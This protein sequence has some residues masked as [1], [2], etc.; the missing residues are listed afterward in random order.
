MIIYQRRHSCFS[1]HS[2]FLAASTRNLA[3]GCVKDRKC[4][5]SGSHN[6]HRSTR[7]WQGHYEWETKFSPIWPQ[8]NSSVLLLH[9]SQMRHLHV[10]PPEV[11]QTLQTLALISFISARVCRLQQI[12]KKHMLYQNTR[13]WHAVYSVH[14]IQSDMVVKVCISEP[15]NHATP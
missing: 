15:E 14:K 12:Q 9:K 5:H 10:L 4:Q 1:V 13:Q 3:I 6:Y 2:C 7:I 11:P 8:Y